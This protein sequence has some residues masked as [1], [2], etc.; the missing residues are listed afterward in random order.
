MSV[1]TVVC[2][3]LMSCSTLESGGLAA[4][5]PGERVLLL[6][7]RLQDALHMNVSVAPA[8]LA[9]EQVHRMSAGSAAAELPAGKIL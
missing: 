1:H 9:W 6:A 5:A 2:K 4:G 8:G 3:L 7:Q